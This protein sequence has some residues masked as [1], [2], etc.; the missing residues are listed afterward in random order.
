M[1]FRQ[2]TQLLAL[3]L[4]KLPPQFEQTSALYLRHWALSVLKE[5]SSLDAQSMERISDA[6]IRA[7]ALPK[8]ELR[9]N[10]RIPDYLSAANSTLSISHYLLDSSVDVL[11]HETITA[12][13]TRD[14][15]A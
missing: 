14:T 7:L 4:H 12:I 10:W 15:G 11:S 5:N 13:A 3:L 9:Q 2:T 8:N 1:D 6:L